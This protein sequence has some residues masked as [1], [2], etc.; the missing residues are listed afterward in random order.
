MAPD[1]YTKALDKALE[2]LEKK[3]LQRDLLTAQITGDKETV[4][5]LSSRIELTPDRQKKVAQLIALVD[6]ATPSLTDAVRSLLT[7][8][9]PADLTAVEVRNR[10][11]DT[12][13]FEES[14]ISLS[15]CHAA[16]KRLVADDLAQLGKAQR[17]GK[18]TYCA[19]LKPTIAR[20]NLAAFYGRI[21]E[22]IDNSWLDAVMDATRTLSDLAGE[23]STAEHP[24]TKGAKFPKK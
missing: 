4:R 10:L 12:P 11:E 13:S 20:G 7:R 23:S 17:G 22:P 19:K 21:G 15:A 1:E 8:I 14:N 16:L 18:P 3:L 9:Y 2:D 24:L 6:S 5:V